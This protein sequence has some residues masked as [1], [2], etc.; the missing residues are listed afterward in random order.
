MSTFISVH[1][2]T[3]VSA[4]NNDA[5]PHIT[6][7]FEGDTFEAR[8]AITLY[9]R[10]EVLNARLIEAINGTMAARTAELATPEKQEAA[11]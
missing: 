8:G 1:N 6:I 10:D 7:E 9:I 4:S 3:K 11:A 2:V 5:V